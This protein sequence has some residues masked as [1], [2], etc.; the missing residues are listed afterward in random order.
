MKK[1]TKI[2]RIII[3]CNLRSSQYAKVREEVL[4]PAR[5][6]Q[7]YMVGKY[8]VK[9][10][11]LTQNVRALAKLLKDDDI[12]VSA[13][14]DATAVIAMNAVMT[15]DAQASLAVL[16]YGNFNDLAR[17]LG[18]ERFAEIFEWGTERKKFYPLE[19]WVDGRLW[20]YASCY[21]TMGMTAEAVK[22]YDGPEMRAKLK[23]EFGRGITSYTE[24]IKWYLKN[25]HKKQFIPEFKLNGDLQPSDTSDYAAVNGRYMARVMKGREDYLKPKRFRSMTDRL[26]VGWRMCWLM[27]K[28]IIDQVPGN[29]TYGDVIEFVRPGSVKLQA[30]GESQLFRGVK[31]IEVK[32]SG[33]WFYAWQR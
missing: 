8:E 21:V 20:R 11:S 32:K 16:P 6:M 13:G 12:V 5:K 17:T 27:T 28:S 29:N 2:K 31:K 3:V 18:V 14:G 7:G 22:L 24:L 4:A 33:K 15:T 23:T 26:A 19:I 10:T 25:R 1:T 30:E 9:K